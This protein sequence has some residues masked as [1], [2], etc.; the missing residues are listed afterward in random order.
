M[1]RKINML[2]SAKEISKQFVDISSEILSGSIVASYGS[3]FQ[4]NTGAWVIGK[5]NNAVHRINFFSYWYKTPIEFQH[6]RV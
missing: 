5:V 3:C 2:S 6:F 4:I 1:S